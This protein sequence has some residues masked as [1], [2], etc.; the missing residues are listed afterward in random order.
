MSARAMSVAGVQEYWHP[1][2]KELRAD[3]DDL[4]AKHRTRAGDAAA[5]PP[6][7]VAPRT[8]GQ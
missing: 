6:V 7:T 3:F 5:T 1:N 4:V 8:T 2:D